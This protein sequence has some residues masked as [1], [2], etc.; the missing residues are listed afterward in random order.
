MKSLNFKIL[1]FLFT[2]SQSLVSQELFSVNKI[3][4]SE[5]QI[6]GYLSEN[7]WFNTKVLPIGFEVEPANN[8]PSKRETF[9][10]VLSVSYTHLR[11]HET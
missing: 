4:H 10:Y 8:K 6:D 3:D 7:V 2:L 1:I 11:A 9:V 5:I